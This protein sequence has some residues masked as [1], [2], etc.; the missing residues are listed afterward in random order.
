MPQGRPR[1]LKI[2][3]NT[4]EIIGLMTALNQVFDS[5]G[6]KNDTQRAAFLE[7]EAKGAKTRLAASEIKLHLLSPFKNKGTIELSEEYCFNLIKVL[8][9][10]MAKYRLKDDE[11]NITRFENYVMQLRQLSGQNIQDNFISIIKESAIKLKPIEGSK[12]YIFERTGDAAI[13][14]AVWGIATG[15]IEFEAQQDCLKATMYLSF[16]G[17]QRKYVGIATTDKDRNHLHI[18]MT[19]VEETQRHNFTMRLDNL[20]LKYQTLM[21][22]HFTYPSKEYHHLL[23]KTVV[24]LKRNPDELPERNFATG[25]HIYGSPAFDKIPA[26]IRQFLNSREMNR[27]S[28]PHV[29]ITNE[30]ELEKFLKKTRLSDKEIEEG[31]ALCKNYFVYY[32]RPDGEITEDQL[33]IY[34]ERESISFK[35]RYTHTPDR[36]GKNSKHWSGILS[37]AKKETGIILILSDEKTKDSTEID[38]PILLTFL[39]PDDEAILIED[40]E[41][42]PG[43]ISG[44]EDFTK[45]PVSYI[46]LVVAAETSSFSRKEDQRLKQFF[47]QYSATALLL[48]NPGFRLD[49]IVSTSQQ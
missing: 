34:L 30:A 43:I 1:R 47:E 14:D 8:N 16:E 32:K 28:F 24:M 3:Y 9:I 6:F 31:T 23:S 13:R 26:P 29:M 5:N 10:C 17:T 4:P 7:E 12:W 39:I 25:N 2:K 11:G 49:E 36:K 35:A 44:L 19:P 22:G 41:C 38:D 18:D 27:M 33:K 46:C 42:F 45:G 40:S 20:H 21:A 37:Y 48:K 15:V